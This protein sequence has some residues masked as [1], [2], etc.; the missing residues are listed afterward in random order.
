MSCEIKK[1]S[2]SDNEMIRATLAF[3]KGAD[4]NSV[5]SS[6]SP[7]TPEE[8]R[9]IEKALL[10]YQRECEMCA[11]VGNDA[12]CMTQ[13]NR[14]YTRRLPWN[15]RKIYPWKNYDWDYAAV[16]ENKYSPAALP[17]GKLK[18]FEGL[19]DDIKNNSEVINGLIR[20]PNPGPS[21]YPNGRNK[22]SDYSIHECRQPGIRGLTCQQ[23]AAIKDRYIQKRPFVEESNAQFFNKPMTGRNSSSFFFQ[24]GYCPRIDI[25]TKKECERRGYKWDENRVDPENS[26]CSQPRYAYVDNTSKP[27]LCGS[28]LEGQLPSIVNNVKDMMT[29]DLLAGMKEMSTGRLEIMQCPPPP[30]PPKEDERQYAAEGFQAKQPRPVREPNIFGITPLVPSIPMDTSRLFALFFAAALILLLAFVFFRDA[31]IKIHSSK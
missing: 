10:E 5:L 29:V 8:R 2:C 31:K 6:I 4:T 7:Y 16:A 19:M 3:L 15:M 12:N 21:S 30:A 28:N 9:E 13:A 1:A 20:H 18:S 26:L 23:T 25:K 11:K 17:R 27:L 22:E 24:I 14:N